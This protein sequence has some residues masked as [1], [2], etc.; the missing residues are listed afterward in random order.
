MHK[1]CGRNTVRIEDGEGIY[2]FCFARLHQKP[3]HDMA[4]PDDYYLVYPFTFMGVTAILSKVSLDEYCGP[5]AES[6]I[7]DLSWI[8]PRACRHENIVE[9]VMCHSPVVPARFGTIFSS[10]NRLEEFLRAHGK[11]LLKCLDH[12]SDKQEWTVKG[13][14]DMGRAKQKLVSEMIA[15]EAKRLAV[16]N[17]GARYFQATD[18]QQLEEV[19]AELDRLEPSVRDK[20]SF[21]PMHSLYM[22][23]AGLALL[24]SLVLALG[25]LPRP[26]P[27]PANEVPQDAR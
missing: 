25:A 10:M 12:L 7:K 20:R 2:L 16:L 21:R 18:A 26:Q 19:Y 27:K 15:A 9:R 17:P 4:G 1:H 24:L 3:I 6:R 23:P 5:S 14:L 13:L 22:W 8:G 11:T